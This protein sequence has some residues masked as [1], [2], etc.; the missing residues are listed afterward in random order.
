MRVARAPLGRLTA[1]MAQLPDFLVIGAK[2]AGTTSLYRY[3][4]DHPDVR[5]TRLFKG[6]HYFDVR[7]D[8]PWWWYRSCFPLRR[9]PAALTGEASPYYMFHPL[10]PGRIATSLPRVRMIAL[11][12]D[13]VERAYS[14]WSFERRNGHETL[15]FEAAVAAEPCRLAGEVE[16]MLAEPGY[17]S[18]A[19]RHHGYLARS[20][21]GEQLSRLYTHVDPTRVLVLQSERLSRNPADELARAWAF[22]GLP[23]HEPAPLRLDAAPPAPPLAADVRM[24]VAALLAPDVERLVRLP[25]VDVCWPGYPAVEDARS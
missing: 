9:P 8:R 19:L 22:L 4:A 13:P 23:P 25:R 16:R 6:S 17:E 2:R 7:Y 24:R 14:Q 3:L 1:C 12:R 20:R 21:Y 18:F 5:S 10:A 11:L 15:D